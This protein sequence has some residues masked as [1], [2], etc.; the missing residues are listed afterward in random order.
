MPRKTETPN[1]EIKTQSASNENRNKSEVY[2]NQ[3][4]IGN[5]INNRKIRKP[6]RGNLPVLD[7]DKIVDQALVRQGRRQSRHQVHA[8]DTWRG[9]NQEKKNT[10]NENAAPQTNG[11]KGNY[12][13]GAHNEAKRIKR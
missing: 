6:E 8:P 4:R 11:E 1:L 5:G 9:T 2:I 3:I 12:R 7:A 10:E 13:R